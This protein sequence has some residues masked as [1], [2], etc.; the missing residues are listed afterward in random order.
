MSVVE[1]YPFYDR[2]PQG[3]WTRVLLLEPGA[4]DD[5]VR[6][7]LH[8]TAFQSAKYAAISYVWG[9]TQN[10]DSIVCQGLE[11]DVTANLVQSLRQVRY[12]DRPRHLWV[13]ALCINQRNLQEKACQV[14]MMG[15]IYSHA[16]MVIIC[17]G[18]DGHNGDAARA[19][20]NT[21]RDYNS[22]AAKY[23]TESQI[24]KDSYWKPTDD[25]GGYG[26]ITGERLLP[27]VQIFKKPWF[28]R[29]WVLQEVGLAKEALLAYGSSTI[30][31]TEIMDFAQAWSRTGNDFPGVHFSAGYISAL[32]N[33]IWATY[34]E[35]VDR[36]WFSHSFIL[37]TSARHMIQINKPELLDV[38]F[39]AQHIQ[40]ATDPRDFVYAFLGHPLAKSDD[41]QLLIE[42]NYERTLLELRMLL[43][44]RLGERSL[45]FL[46]LTWHRIAADLSNGPSWCP[47]LGSRRPWTMNGRYDASRGEKWLTQAKNLP[48]RVIDS[49]LDT[50]IYVLDKIFLCGKVAGGEPPMDGSGQAIDDDAHRMATITELSKQPS[51]VEEYWALLEA[52]E[53]IH[54]LAYEDKVLAF[55]STL[56]HAFSGDDKDPGSVFR[57]FCTFCKEYCPTIQADLEKYE[58]LDQLASVKTR[59]IP[60]LPRTANEIKGEKFFTTWK[61]YCGTSTPLIEPGDLI[62]IIPSVQTPMVIRP[63]EGNDGSFKIIGSSYVRGMMYGEVFKTPAPGHRFPDVSIARFV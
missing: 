57:S 35:N 44:S 45:R 1:C 29:V 51:I 3:K 55:A 46:G 16:W 11:I 59:F 19:A 4:H 18:D 60:F 27:A 47:S 20:F 56:L 58:W 9:N 38:L 23:M 63:V 52:T 7:S 25:E 24:S 30:N 5:P 28:G 13:D 48:P 6:C 40:K 15:E 33:H 49:C 42:A 43:F 31:F 32:F 14:D 37:K 41:G 8:P 53:R 39:K 10:T 62:C 17:L 12:T 21:I 2:L 36:S 26:L 61:G 50:S 22:I 54:K 34:A